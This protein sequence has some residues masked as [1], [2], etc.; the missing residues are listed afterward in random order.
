MDEALEFLQEMGGAVHLN[1]IYSYVAR[2]RKNLPKT[3]KATV[4]RTLQ[5]HPLMTQDEPASGL[6]R[7][8]DPEELRYEL[9]LRD[10]DM[11]ALRDP[12]DYERYV[13]QALRHL[14][15]SATERDIFAMVKKLRVA[16]EVPTP[17]SYRNKVRKAL[18]YGEHFQQ[19]P[20]DE[21][22][23]C[24]LLPDTQDTE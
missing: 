9:A 13:A 21:R 17:G 24:L 16:M 15:Y 1:E 20:D 22:V 3:W 10:V 6:W 2:T 14:N 8:P 11:E 23:W 7:L 4:R 19:L 12:D 18:K 5:Q